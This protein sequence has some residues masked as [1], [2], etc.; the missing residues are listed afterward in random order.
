MLLKALGI[1]EPEFVISVTIAGE[2]LEQNADQVRGSTLIWDFNIL[3]PQPGFEPTQSLIPLFQVLALPNVWRTYRTHRYRCTSFIDII[4]G[5]A[6][7]FRCKE[8]RHRNRLSLSSCIFPS[9]MRINPANM[10]FLSF[11]FGVIKEIE[12]RSHRASEF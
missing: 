8:R 10:H 4:R 12:S 5:S 3:D 11:A 2:I 1:P 9:A 6:E 7:A